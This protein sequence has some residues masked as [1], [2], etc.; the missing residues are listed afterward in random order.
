MKIIIYVL[1][2]DVRPDGLKKA[3]V[4]LSPDYEALELANKLGII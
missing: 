3:Y 4:K 1:L 2:L